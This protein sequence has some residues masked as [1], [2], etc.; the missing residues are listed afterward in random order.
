MEELLLRLAG[1][2]P[3]AVAM[4]I[5]VILFLKHQ[6]RLQERHDA[7]EDANSVR[8]DTAL[9]DSREVTRENTISNTRLTQA[10]ETLSA[11]I[12]KK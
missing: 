1:N 11:N 9:A 7:T 5:T 8:W 12:N 3:T 10:V 4:I 2:S 6:A